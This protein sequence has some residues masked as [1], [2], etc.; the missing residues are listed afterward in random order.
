[1][2]SGKNHDRAGIIANAI[3]LLSLDPLIVAGSFLGWCYLSPDVDTSSKPF[4]RWGILSP[5]W[6]PLQSVTKHRGITHV[7]VVGAIALQLYLAGL[8]LIGVWIAGGLN[9]LTYWLDNNHQLAI[10]W[11]VRFSLGHIS[12][13]LLHL[14]L[15]WCSDRPSGK[16]LRNKKR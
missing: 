15:D 1:M 6:Y 8:V 7:P 4:Y 12:Q 11:W 13:Q 3:A 9:Y 16:F 10:D 14:A 2:A 5:I